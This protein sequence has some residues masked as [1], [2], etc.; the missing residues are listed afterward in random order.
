MECEAFSGPPRVSHGKAGKLG[1]LETQ[2]SLSLERC[3]GLK[4][5]QSTS[6]LPKSLRLRLGCCRAEGG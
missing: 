2:L 4:V 5:A 6:V 3:G 1:T